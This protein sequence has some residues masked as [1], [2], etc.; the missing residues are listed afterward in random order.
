MDLRRHVDDAAINMAGQYAS[1]PVAGALLLH[2]QPDLSSVI[3]FIPAERAR[4]ASRAVDYT[5]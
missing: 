3:T 1:W 4:C 2:P 5:G